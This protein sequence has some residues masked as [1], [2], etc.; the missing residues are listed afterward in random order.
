MEKATTMEEVQKLENVLVT[1]ILQ[2][3]LANPS[4]DSNKVGSDTSPHR[5]RF[6]V[7]GVHSALF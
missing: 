4:D 3:S 5:V 7:F 2:P 1:G 6:F